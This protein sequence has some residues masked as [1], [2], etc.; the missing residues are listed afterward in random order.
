[1]SAAVLLLIA[2]IG[3]GILYGARRG[4][5]GERAGWSARH[6]KLNLLTLVIVMW[7]LSVITS[8]G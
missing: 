4:S 3:F 8:V 7:I 1:M 6:R 2:V 5:S